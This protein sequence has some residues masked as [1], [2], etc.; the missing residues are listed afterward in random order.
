MNEIN[1]I[2]RAYIIW[3]F[4]IIILAGVGIYLSKIYLPEYFLL[5]TLGILIIGYLL[6]AGIIASYKE[7]YYEKVLKPTLEKYGIEY[8]PDFGLNESIAR[9]SG[10]L[11]S[12]DIYKSE[13]Y[14]RGTSFEAAKITLKVIEETRDS[15]GN[16]QRRE[17][18]VFNGTLLVYFSDKEII[19][20]FIITS[21]TFHLSDLFPF[22]VDK[23]RQKMDDPKFEEYFDIYGGDD[24]EVR[25]ILTHDIMKKLI[26]LKEET[27]FSK[28]SFIDTLRF[29]SFNKMSP[30]IYP[31]IFKKVTD[32]VVLKS[33][34]NALK[35]KIVAD[36]FMENRL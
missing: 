5:S 18:T 3:F 29:V 24:I 7:D 23:N 35:L 4:I 2:R 27:K 9:A 33:I 16:I 19:E 11:P 21:S 15:E 26:E 17:K 8:L 25:K 20:P 13:D 30:I 10:L 6:L 1:E 12:Y 36:F 28:I 32:K 31:S 22:F 34:S 14:I